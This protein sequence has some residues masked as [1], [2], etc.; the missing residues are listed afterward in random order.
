MKL[1]LTFL[2]SANALAAD[3]S[4]LET[5]KLSSGPAS[6]SVRFTAPGKGW[7][8][9]LLSR[10]AAP[11]EPSLTVT[12]FKHE[13]F[14]NRFLGVAMDGTADGPNQV[15]AKTVRD[16]IIG[17]HLVGAFTEMD[18]ALDSGPHELVFRS[19]G[20]TAELFIDGIRRE[21]R[22][23]ERL[24]ARTYLK[25]YPHAKLGWKLGSDPDGGDVFSGTIEKAEVQPQWLSDAEIG[26]KGTA[27]ENT[28]NAK[29]IAAGLFPASMSDSQ[30]MS[31]IDDAMPRWLADTMKRDKWFP[32]FHL[33]IPA[34]M[35]FDTRCAIHGGRF[36]VFPT[37]RANLNLTRGTF[38]SFRMMHASSADLVHW[39]IEPFPIRLENADVC[40]GS[41][42]TLDGTPNFFFLRFGTNGA[43]NRA[44]PSDATLTKWSLAEPPPTITKEGEGY[45]GRLDSVVFTHGGKTYLTGTRRNANK[46]SMAMPLYRSDDLT[47]WTYHGDFLQTDTG[48]NFNECPQIFTLGDKMVVAAFYPLKG[49]F[50]NH[51][52]GRFENERFIPETSGRWD[53]GGHGHVRSFDADTAPD[54]RVIGWS[55]ISVYGEH[56][57]LETA[58]IG[59]KGMHSLPKEVTLRPD[60]TLALAP[61]QEIEQLRGEMSANSLPKEHDGTFE[62]AFTLEKP[63]RLALTSPDGQIS[64]TFD[65]RSR[66]L[67]ADATKSPKLGSDT[68]H[69]FRTDAIPGEGAVPCRVFFDRSVLEIYVGGMVMTLR[70]YPADPASLQFTQRGLSSFTAWKMNPIW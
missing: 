35:M 66:T 68:G 41:P 56:D 65:P 23:A 61:A 10:R 12:A 22:S 32:R 54:G 38:G 9:T 69:L 53:Y 36:H 18:A 7:T 16:D 67:T 28:E 19:D 27:P 44:T 2:V 51:L 42:T 45:A 6:I 30:R 15:A 31:A 70:H 1:F 4:H 29:I 55:T 14:G 49:R 64:L 37:W 59:W 5:L 3:I 39:R 25:L 46:P 60:G 8:G 43:P 26:V 34:G 62:L 21:S 58:R 20:K 47:S 17:G 24:T 57:A 48:K 52:V 13:P 11:G 50:D 63:A 33:A 40:N